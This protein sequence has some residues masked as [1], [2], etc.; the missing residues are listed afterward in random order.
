MTSSPAL[1]S[2]LHP[3]S[4]HIRKLWHIFLSSF[5]PLIKIIHQPSAQKAIEDAMI[6]LEHVPRGLEAL[7]FS[8]YNAAIFTMR[9]EECQSIFGESRSVLQ[10][11][12]R[13]G[14]RRCL[15]RAH[16]MS[17]SDMLVLQA[18]ILYL[19]SIYHTIVSTH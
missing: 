18:L 17:S 2:N 8:I 11:R 4:D 3:S 15:T 16:F 5:N 12:Y 14:V 10:S 7:M 13:L 1:T 6:D 9:P 19:V